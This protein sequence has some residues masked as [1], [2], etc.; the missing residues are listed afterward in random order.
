MRFIFLISFVSIWK[1]N[2]PVE[3]IATV[4]NVTFPLSKKTKATK[5]AI[6][7]HADYAVDTHAN[8]IAIV[9]LN[10]AVVPDGSEMKNFKK[11][12][13]LMKNFCLETIKLAT[14]ATD[15]TADLYVGKALR[16]SRAFK[17][18]WGYFSD[19]LC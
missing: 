13:K 19:F 17:Y 3:G 6:T 10:A 4:V 5:L 18:V 12:S 11:L 9:K 14:L 15:T 1:S 16:V 2:S 7:A 8:N